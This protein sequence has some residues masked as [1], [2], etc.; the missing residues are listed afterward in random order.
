[1]ENADSIQASGYWNSPEG[2]HAF[3]M[4]GEELMEGAKMVFTL[5]L[6]MYFKVVYCLVVAAVFLC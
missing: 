5:A 6:Q 2:S 4:N 1:M 3:F